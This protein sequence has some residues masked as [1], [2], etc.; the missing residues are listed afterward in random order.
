M[1][2]FGVI[3]SLL[4]VYVYIIIIRAVVSWFSPNPNNQ[5]Y[6][7]LIDVTEPALSRIRRIMPNI[8][9]IDFSPLVL[10]LIIQ[11]AIRG[12]LLKLLFAGM[13]M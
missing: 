3:D 8:G 11:W 10:I 12:F 1:F 9:G 2:L 6:R 4:G 13:G 5:F 7:I